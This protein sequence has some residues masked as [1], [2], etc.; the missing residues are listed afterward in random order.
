MIHMGLGSYSPLAL[1]YGKKRLANLGTLGKPKKVEFT[2][3]PMNQKNRRFWEAVG[4]LAGHTEST[5]SS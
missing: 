4:L 5:S 1:A 3:E 2:S